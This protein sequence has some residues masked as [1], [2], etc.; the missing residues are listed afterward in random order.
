MNFVFF[1]PQAPTGLKAKRGETHV[2][3]FLEAPLGGGDA[4]GLSLPQKP[5]VSH[6]TPMALPAPGNK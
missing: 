1:Y 6:A 2:P 3:P 5:Q 4:Q